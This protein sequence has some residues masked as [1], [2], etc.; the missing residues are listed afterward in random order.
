[1]KSDTDRHITVFSDGR[2]SGHISNPKINWEARGWA[3]K[4]DHGFYIGWWFTK[5][6]AIKAHTGELG[7]TWE[8]CRKNGDKAVRIRMVEE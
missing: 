3:I 6:E 1:M 2:T 4:G 7:K 8:D 5:K